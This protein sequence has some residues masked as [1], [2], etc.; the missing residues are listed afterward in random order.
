[1]RVLGPNWLLDCA[2]SIRGLEVRRLNAPFETPNYVPASLTGYRNMGT[3]PTITHDFKPNP[4]SRSFAC[5]KLI[6]GRSLP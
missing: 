6:A 1:M 2:V 4:Y 5:V 3:V